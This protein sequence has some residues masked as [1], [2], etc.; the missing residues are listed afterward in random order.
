[1]LKVN[2]TD[3]ILFA[4]FPLTLCFS[5]EQWFVSICSPFLSLQDFTAQIHA[6]LCQ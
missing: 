1:M 3:S 6:K 4:F 2:Y 5:L